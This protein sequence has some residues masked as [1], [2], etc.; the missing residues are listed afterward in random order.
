MD[1]VELFPVFAFVAYVEVVKARLPERARQLVADEC[2]LPFSF[3]LSRP[4]LARDTLLEYL[5]DDRWILDFRL[6][7]QQMKVLGHDHV[8]GHNKLGFLS[9]FLK[10]LQEQGSALSRSAEG[11]AVTSR[12]R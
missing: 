12:N 5:H 3:P 11:Q 1:V 4:A 2:E 6:P 8:A 10:N 7:D 9:G